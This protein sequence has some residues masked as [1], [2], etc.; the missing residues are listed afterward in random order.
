[1]DNLQKANQ[2]YLNNYSKDVWYGRCI[3]L[4][5]YCEVGTCKFCFRSTIHHKV[6]HAQS[7]RRSIPS[8]LV[9]ALLC[10]KLNWRIEF[11]T[12]GY[13]AYSFEELKNICRLISKVY[14]EKIWVNLGTLTEEERN[15]L[16][17]YV[18]GV[19]ASLE[20]VNPKLHTEICPDKP[21]QPYIEMLKEIKDFK[22][23]ITI[24][25]GLGETLDDFPLLEKTIKECDLDRITF[26]A[27]KPVKGTGYTKGPD[28]S[29]YAE[30]IAKTRIAFPKLQIIAGTTARRVEE[31]DILLKAGANAITKFPATKLFNTEESRMFAEKVK[32]AGRNLT[33]ELNKLTNVDW[34]REVDSLDIEEEL[35][36]ELKEKLKD[37]L[38][39]MK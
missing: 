17:P 22:K 39:K 34:N 23:S 12:G 15:I 30:W 14:G 33:S 25:I 35:K 19:V 6:K 10:K 31:I 3:F 27:L 26:Y 36:T 38:N 1:M 11:L 29:Y 32:I 37:Y 2:V 13:R 16:K 8:M 18:K 7:A 24:V 5:W 9:E 20:T 4:S 28:T 21:M